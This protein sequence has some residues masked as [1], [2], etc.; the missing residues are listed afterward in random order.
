MWDWKGWELSG[1]GSGGREPEAA[2][3]ETTGDL[4]R[5]GVGKETIS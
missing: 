2:E 1:K 3:E 5:V 4:K